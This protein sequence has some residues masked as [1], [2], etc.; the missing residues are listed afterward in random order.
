MKDER[1]LNIIHLIRVK[2]FQIAA[3]KYIELSGGNPTDKRLVTHLAR[4]IKAKWNAIHRLRRNSGYTN[5]EI[6]E[7][8]LDSLEE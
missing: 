4:S 7:E 8:I 2:R 6:A 3:E 5:D 1:L